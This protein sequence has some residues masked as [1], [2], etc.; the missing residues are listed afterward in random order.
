[1]NNVFQHKFNYELGDPPTYQEVSQAIK[2]TASKKSPGQTAITTNVLKNLPPEAF[3]FL[4]KIIQQYWMNPKCDF[5]L[6]HIVLLSIIYK[7]KGDTKDPQNWRPMCLKE[8]LVKVLS[9]IV[10]KHLLKQII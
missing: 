10:S 6:W 7:G 4:T 2:R 9:S 8:T 5:A 1:M 3:A